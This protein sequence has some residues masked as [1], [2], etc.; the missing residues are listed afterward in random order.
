MSIDV[1]RLQI[2]VEE[3]EGWR[4]TL[5]VTVP[6]DEVKR[7]RERL[8][9]RL[10]KR[11]KLPGF[12]KGR[13]PAGVLE[14]RYGPV[15]DRETL[16][17]L[18][19][20]A[21]R[22]ALQQRELRPISEGEVQDV[23]FEPEQDLMFSIS[24]DVQPEIE[25]GRLGGFTVERPAVE[26]GDEEVERVLERLRQQQGTWTTAEGGPPEDGDV[27]DVEVTRLDDGDDAEPK[28]YQLML[29]QGDALPDVEAAIRTLEPGGSGE[30]VVRF[31]ED[32][33]DEARRGEEQHLRITL[34]ERRVLELPELD[35]AFAQAVG[36]FENLEALR[37]RVREDLEK[38][39][40]EQADQAAR[41]QLLDAVIEANPFT[42]PRSMVKAYIDSILG[43]PDGVQPEQLAEA[44]ERLW[45][46]AERAVKRI[47]VIERVADQQGLRA[48]E[49]D[50][51][52]R[53]EEIAERAGEEPG[54]VYA[55]LQ[56]A[57]R[58]EALER[59]ITERRVFEFLEGQ[60]EIR[61]GT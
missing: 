23:R 28:P 31:P 61:Q 55:N 48:T 4:R 13:I 50:L 51:D 44:Y 21:Y 25:L 43:N 19:G 14:K 2:A 52:R 10:A 29:G 49:E 45:P 22:G 27:V 42:V 36:D 34:K 46:E 41:T 5:Q 18:I 1:S 26:V 12:R 47:L 37:A 6:A 7:E 33:P 15:L 30:F 16:D 39:A 20:E 59:D 35:D 11:L 57:N 58:L 9:K 53:I 60:S 56:K 54:R 38:E 40:N 24:F 32:F 3:G 8:A 17:T